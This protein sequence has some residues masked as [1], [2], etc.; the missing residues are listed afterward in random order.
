MQMGGMAL[1]G[2]F[3][4]GKTIFLKLIKTAEKAAAL[5]SKDDWHIF[6]TLAC[7]LV[8]DNQWEKAT[9]NIRHI[10]NEASEEFFKQ[11]WPQRLHELT[12]IYCQTSTRQSQHCVDRSAPGLLCALHRSETLFP[13]I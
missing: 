9:P 4:N 3:I 7:V 13:G 5:A 2:C 12:A 1:P 11:A 10:F 8:T 6:H